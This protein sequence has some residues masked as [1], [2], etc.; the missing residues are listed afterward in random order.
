MKPMAFEALDDS[1][2]PQEM[3]ERMSCLGLFMLILSENI[4]EKEVI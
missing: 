3:D 4:P 2:S 1:L